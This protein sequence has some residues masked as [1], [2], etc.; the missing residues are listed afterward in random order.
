V[1]TV[2]LPCHSR[3][4]L[5]Y[6]SRRP[7][8]RSTT[9]IRHFLDLVTLVQSMTLTDSV[10]CLVNNNRQKETFPFFL[11]NNLPALIS[12]QPKTNS[13]AQCCRCLQLQELWNPQTA[14][15]LRTKAVTWSFALTVPP[16]SS[17]IRCVSV[18]LIAAFLCLIFRPSIEHQRR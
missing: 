1:Q 16:T 6:L 7:G 14:N 5:F 12:P 8:G 18:Y 15:A 13:R 3:A 10:G 17:A 2:I 11:Q 9:I 4:L